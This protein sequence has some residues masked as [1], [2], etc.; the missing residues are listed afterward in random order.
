[1]QPI[2]SNN[3]SAKEGVLAPV[4]RAFTLLR[5]ILLATCG[6]LLGLGLANA[7]S[8]CLT[9]AGDA[10]CDRKVDIADFSMFRAQFG[11]LVDSWETISPVDFNDDNRIDILDFSILRANFG[12]S[13]GLP[14]EVA[15]LRDQVPLTTVLTLTPTPTRTQLPTRTATKTLTVSPTPSQTAMPCQDTFTRRCTQLSPTP[16]GPFCT[17]PVI[18]RICALDAT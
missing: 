1:L 12:R 2:I 18:N 8:F 3:N 5:A 10:N 9:I 14:G 15:C 6:V 17:T 4:P 13:C 11:R 16:Y 7:Q